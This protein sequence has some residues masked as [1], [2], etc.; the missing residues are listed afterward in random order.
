MHTLTRAKSDDLTR[1]HPDP[2][3][4][5]RGSIADR[6]QDQDHT[7]RHRDKGGPRQF[8][9]AGRQVQAVEHNLGQPR[10]ELAATG[11]QESDNAFLAQGSLKIIRLTKY[12]RESARHFSLS[13]SSE[14]GF[15]RLRG[16]H[17]KQVCDE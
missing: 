5:R 17:S 1:S 15:P 11:D 8:L 12:R 14:A 10:S 7:L 6:R 16:W 9:F 3:P 2:A 13:P 4:D